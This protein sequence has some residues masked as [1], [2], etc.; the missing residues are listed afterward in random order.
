MSLRF[1][2]FFFCLIFG[3]AGF[4]KLFFLLLSNLLV[5]PQLDILFDRLRPLVVEIASSF[6]VILPLNMGFVHLILNATALGQL[7]LLFDLIEIL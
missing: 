7:K 3:L 4:E 5:L 1:C 2:L 6:F